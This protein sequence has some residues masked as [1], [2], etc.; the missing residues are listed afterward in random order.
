MQGSFRGFS[1]N[2]NSRRD[3]F[4]AKY[5]PNFPCF[6]YRCG[7]LP[8]LFLEWRIAGV[9]LIWE[10]EFSDCFSA[11]ECLAF[12]K[13]TLGSLCVQSGAVIFGPSLAQRLFLRN[14]ISS[15][16]RPRLDVARF[17]PF[18]LMEW[19]FLIAFFVSWGT[20]HG[21][22]SKPMQLIIGDR[23]L[24]KLVWLPSNHDLRYHQIFSDE[25]SFF[26]SFPAF[27]SNLNDVLPITHHARD[28]CSIRNQRRKRK[29]RRRWRILSF[30]WDPSVREY[31]LAS[32][33][34]C[35]NRLGRLRD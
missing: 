11:L 22:I 17:Q 2:Q 12:D 1:M 30:P 31:I 19:R 7:T 20:S 34:N 27:L 3:S 4:F 16:T 9:F 28:T 32:G 15:Y 5:R 23:T 25:K 14:L 35:A 13:H 21:V 8:S 26:W 33:Q 29:G 18:S 6:L 24:F 10:M